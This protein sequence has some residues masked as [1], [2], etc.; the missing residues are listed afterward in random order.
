MN[1]QFTGS[2]KIALELFRRNSPSRESLMEYPEL[3]DDQAYGLRYL[4]EMN[5]QEPRI[6]Q[7][8]DSYQLLAFPEADESG[9]IQDIIELSVSEPKVSL[10]VKYIKE[11]NEEPEAF[12]ERVV[13]IAEK[14]NRVYEE[15]VTL[16]EEASS[17]S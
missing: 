3:K 9:Q 13:F 10:V 4:N 7:L 8:P 12:I 17:S 15:I 1:I 11:E 14:V 6:K 16:V 5:K 2:G